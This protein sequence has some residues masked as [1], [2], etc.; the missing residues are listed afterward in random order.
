MRLF[1]RRCR[2]MR[3]LTVAD[4]IRRA[5]LVC[6]PLHRR[7]MRVLCSASLCQRGHSHQQERSCF[8]ATLRIQPSPRSP[9]PWPLSRCSAC[10]LLI[11][12]YVLSSGP[13]GTLND[14]SILIAAWLS[15][16]LA[17]SLHSQLAARNPLLAT[18]ALILTVVGAVIATY[19][20]VL[21]I[22]GR[23]G[24]ILAGLYMMVGNALIGIWL[25]Q[26][27]PGCLLAAGSGRPWSDC[28]RRHGSWAWLPFLELSR[29][30]IRSRTRPGSPG[31]VRWASSAGRSSTPSGACGFGV[32]FAPDST[33]PQCLMKRAIPSRMRGSFCFPTEHQARTVCGIAGMPPPMRMPSENEGMGVLPIPSFSV[34]LPSPRGRGRA[35]GPLPAARTSQVAPCDVQLRRERRH[36]AA[37]EAISA[38]IHACP[39]Q[40]AC[41][42]KMRD[43]LP[44]P[45]FGFSPLPLGEWWA[46]AALTPS[47]SRSPSCN[48]T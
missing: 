18:L 9:L 45:H 31:S 10:V 19:G 5:S 25:H 44:I 23:T 32:S 6:A 41:P 39:L 46:P 35:A 48:T 7:S 15:V 13:L 17:W 24:F 47:A 42:P 28:R 4:R 11:L 43:G 33:S 30:R 12:M 20:S 8:P 38:M 21:I 3:Q 16:A 36:E 2:R 27:Q 26:P 14:V 40:G 29:A 22:S 37:E 34:S 1:P